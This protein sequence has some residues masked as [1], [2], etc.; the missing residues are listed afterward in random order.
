MAMNTDGRKRR[1]R[2]PHTP[3]TAARW[4]AMARL[5]SDTSMR[6][7][8]TSEEYDRHLASLLA[9][10]DFAARLERVQRD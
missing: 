1:K 5:L 6:E 8:W 2:K 4:L 3:P 7:D 10:V 9:L